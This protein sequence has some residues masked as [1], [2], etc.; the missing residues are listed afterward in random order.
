MRIRDFRYFARNKFP[1]GQ[2]PPLQGFYC[3]SLNAKMCIAPKT[4]SGLSFIVD[5]AG[6]EVDPAQKTDLSV[7]NNGF[8]VIPVM[9][10]PRKKRQQHRHERLYFDAC[11]THGF[12]VGSPQGGTAHIVV[13]KANFNPCFSFFNEN[14]PYP[15]T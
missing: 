3:I 7:D 2:K 13:Y 1:V 4:I 9:T 5:I 11:I 8:P 6:T 15:A 14:I 10:C 12:Q